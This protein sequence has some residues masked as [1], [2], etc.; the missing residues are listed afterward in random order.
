MRDSQHL[1][2]VSLIELFSCKKKNAITLTNE[3]NQAAVRKLVTVFKIE[4]R[5]LK[6]S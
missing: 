6:G 5:D 2:L 3:E 4:F 1:S